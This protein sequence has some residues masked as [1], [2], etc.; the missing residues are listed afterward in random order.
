MPVLNKVQSVSF[1]IFRYFI[2]S[3]PQRYL[4]PNLR[5]PWMMTVSSIS[6]V[7]RRDTIT[8]RRH[9][10]TRLTRAH[11]P[12]WKKKTRINKKKS[13]LANGFLSPF[14]PSPLA[15]DLIDQIYGG[16]AMESSLKV[17]LLPSSL[18]ILS[19]FAK[20]TRLGSSRSRLFFLFLCLFL[21]SY[22]Y[23]LITAYN[24][25]Q[26]RY[27][28]RIVQKLVGFPEE[29]MNTLNVPTDLLD[30]SLSAEQLL[31]HPLLGH[32]EPLDCGMTSYHRER[33][34]PLFPGFR[35][36]SSSSK[37]ANRR[38]LP[39]H[40]L[41][42]LIAIN[43]I[44]AANVFPTL[45]RAIYSLIKL[46]EGSSPRGKFHISIYENG[47]KDDTPVQ[48][49][50]LARLFQKLG[51]G[52]T[53]ISSV[54]EEGKTQGSRISKLSALRNEA[55][56]PVFDNPAGTF[57]RIIFL[58]DVHLCETDL[59]ELLF[60]NE[61]QEA[62]MSCGMD[63]KDLEIPEFKDSGYPLIFYDTWVARDMAGLYVR[64]RCVILSCAKLTPV[65]NQFLDLSTKSLNPAVHGHSLPTPSLS[66]PLDSDSSLSSRSKSIHVGMASPSFELRYSYPLTTFGSGPMTTPTSTRNAI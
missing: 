49:Y 58:N 33:Y 56:K 44:D 20:S 43:L 38:N 53:I 48:L 16:S 52:Y 65:E 46:T 40:Q 34:A 31:Q 59:L 42:Y 57:D 60:S 25:S 6:D 54:A 3:S 36:R 51:L 55:L 24:Y 28:A 64:S 8:L 45:L 14:S 63:Y 61:V 47:S 9:F 66:L 19:A 22:L 1:L 2:F 7:H 18:P 32:V 35:Q 39:H 29:R 26:P 11:A 4:I 10:R 41:N 17:P 5:N 13:C 12:K 27:K 50:L 62:D 15:L 21:F 30:S 37:S 23:S